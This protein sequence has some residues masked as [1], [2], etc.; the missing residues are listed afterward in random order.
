MQAG[1]KVNYQKILDDTIATKQKEGV[2]PKLLLHSCCAP[3]SSYVLEYLSQYFEITVLYYNPNISPASEYAARVAEQER[4]IKEFPA[5]YPI[6]FLAGAYHPEEFY[7]AVKGLEDCPEGGKRCTIC[8]E[9]RL[10]E[11]AEAAVSGGFDYFTTT[12]SISP[13]KDAE[14]LNSI[15]K[16]LAEEYGV[17]Y[18]Y[19][20]FKKKN[21]YKRSTE[22]SAQYGLYRQNYCGCVF[23]KEEQE[24]RRL[25]QEK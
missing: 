15:G 25:Q 5:K 11:A 17:A 6:S 18:L 20:D 7:A 4:L 13:L 14:R 8:F 21:G 10:R 9:L 3:C 23:S 12:L 1:Q 16:A 24:K 19:S 2:V 22:L